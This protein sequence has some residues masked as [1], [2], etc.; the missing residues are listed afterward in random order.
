MVLFL[1]GL[2]LYDHK[3]ITLRGLEAVKTCSKVRL[4]SSRMR[5]TSSQRR[6]VRGD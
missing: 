6:R 4:S 5:S 1:I 3:D 2:G